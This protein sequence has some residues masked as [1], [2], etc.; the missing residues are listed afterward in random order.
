M[1]P[2]SSTK[3]ESRFNQFIRAVGG[4]NVKKV[5]SLLD[6]GFEIDSSSP[7]TDGF[8]GLHFASQEGDEPMVSLLLSRGA[9]LDLRTGKSG[10]TALMLA[11]NFGKAKI[12]KR[13]LAAGAT[14]DLR[15]PTMGASALMMASNN[16][17]TEVVIDLLSGGANANQVGEKSWEGKTALLIALENGC[18]ETAYA[19]APHSSFQADQVAQFMAWMH[20][21]QPTEANMDQPGV[22]GSNEHAMPVT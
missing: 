13:L 15:E 18:A 22:L 19:L 4:S 8:T 14:L 9:S 11:S 10:M 17:W 7:R 21:H 2:S 5:A 20:K 3:T 1:T 12:V 6:D 16:G